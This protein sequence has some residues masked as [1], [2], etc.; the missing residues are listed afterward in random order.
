MKRI[1]SVSRRTD[2]P[3]FYGEWFIQRLKE[4]FAGYVNPF[5][6]QRYFVSLKPEDVL[7]F[8]FW[9]KNFTPF[10][11]K[12]KIIED[13]G[14]NFYFNY[15]LTGL[16]KIFERFV[17][18]ESA[19][20]A[21][22]ELSTAYSPKHINWRYDPIIISDITGY[23][24]HLKNFEAIASE[25]QGYV[26][27]CYFSFAVQYGKVKRNF[28]KLQF[29]ND[30]KIVD[31]VSFKIKLANELADIA[32]KYGIKMLSCCGNY[33]LSGKIGK[34]HCVDGKVIKE[35]FLK[36]FRYNEKP[37]RK[38]CGCTESVDVG[39]YDTC[40]HGCVYCYA[41]VNKEIAG[42]RYESHDKSSAFLGCTKEESDAF[43]YEEM[44]DA[45]YS[46]TLLDYV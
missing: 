2:I 20:R 22:K 36:E 12:L 39:A 24:F 41:N 32:Q 45:G 5:G 17:I 19:I 25:L 34:A 8:V 30:I 10:I 42:A 11:K 31:D 16:P 3:A 33:L 28:E 1:I 26:E 9:S 35:L 44:K 6:G 18:K 21:L 13:M 46:T 14:Y 40:P 23:N 29:E 7:C 43:A 15:T 27:R 4:G 37:T 38:E